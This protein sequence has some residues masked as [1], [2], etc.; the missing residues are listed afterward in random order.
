MSRHHNSA[1]RGEDAQPDDGAPGSTDRGTISRRQMLNT[2]GVGLGVMAVGTSGASGQTSGQYPGMDAPDGYRVPAYSEGP[3]CLYLNDFGGEGDNP[4]GLIHFLQYVDYLRVEGICSTQPIPSTDEIHKQIDMYEEHY[5]NY[6][7]HSDFPTPDELRDITYSAASSTQSG[8]TPSGLSETAE[9][10]I[11]RAHADEE[12]PLY[13]CVGGSMTEVA[14][15]L[16]EDPS[17]K[18]SIRVTSVGTWN[19]DQD[20]A[21]RDYVYNEHPDLWWVESDSAYA[22]TWTAEDEAGVD[23]CGYMEEHVHGV[24]ALGDYWATI[25]P[26]CMGQ[27]CWQTGDFYTYAILL[28]GDPDDPTSPSWGGRWQPTDHGPNYWTDLSGTTIGKWADDY[29]ADFARRLEWGVTVGI[30]DD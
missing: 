20:P 13:V 14:Q 1:G 26:C 6:R 27:G 15:A 29:F 17:I 5:E 16:H 19:T 7:T 30:Q 12:D 22:G 28:H 4:Q 25:E 9:R 3:R 21:A 11:E 24:G 8:S 18:D 23:S 10:I 2:V